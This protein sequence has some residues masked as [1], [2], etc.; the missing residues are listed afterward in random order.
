MAQ[1]LESISVPPVISKEECIYCYQSPYNDVT[2]NELTCSPR[3]SLNVCLHCFQSVCGRH[4]ALHY[5]VVLNVTS[6]AHSTYFNLAKVKK[7]EDRAEQDIKNKKIKL[8]VVEKSEDEIYENLW[9]LGEFDETT[10]S[11]QSLC[12]SKDA[13]LSDSVISKANQILSSKSQDMV[14]QTSSWELTIK[15]CPHVDNFQPPRL[16]LTKQTGSACTDCGLSG[17]LWLCLHCGNVGCG[18]NQVGVEGHSHA[19]KHYESNPT[20]PIA[21]KLGSLSKN[22]SDL[23]CYSC[24][25]ETKFEDQRPFMIALKSYGINLEDKMASEKTLVELQV[26]QNMNWDFQMTDSAGKDLLKLKPNQE[27]G[28]GLINLGNSCYLNSVLQCLFNGGVKAWSLRGLGQDFPQDV[29]YPTNNLTCQ[30]IKLNNA[31]KVEPERYPEGIRPKSFKKCVGQSHQEFSSERQ[32]DAMEFLGYFVDVLDKNMFKNGFNPNDLMKFAM[33]DRLQCVNCGK[34]KYSSEAAESIQLPMPENDDPQDLV[35]IITQYFSGEEVEFTC[36]HCKTLVKAIKKPAFNTYPNTLVVTPARIR[37]INWVPVKTSNELSLPGLQNSNETLDISQFGSEG[38]DP[39]KEELMPEDENDTRFVPN[40]TA[41][42]QL[43]E[44]GFQP[45]GISRALFST[46]N[47]DAESAMEWLFQHVEDPDLNE[48][49]EP[50]KSSNSATGDTLKVNP[51]LLDNMTAMG[52]DQKLSLKAL[53]LNKGDVNRSVEWVFN[54]MD[55][56]GE[57]PQGPTV[58]NPKDY[59]H[60]TP[61]PYELT[62]IICHKGNS[63]HSGHYVAFIRQVVDNEKKWVL[64]NDEKIVVAV[65][66]NFEEMKKNGYIYLYSRI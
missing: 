24:D 21:V 58:R 6:S 44:M 63:V 11:L 14:D 43:A 52:L 32:Q 38:F 49:F 25:D 45:N 2:L 47:S 4:L 20:H 36:P 8:R 34:V 57:L 53:V 31:M 50:P 29:V 3:H 23:Y 5:Q 18:R 51:E 48:P 30:L 54:N 12:T 39:T 7:P 61:E 1:I 17:N 13:N 41:A 56:D 55:D 62:G 33:E 22:A 42:S 16:E 9:S 28:C 46:G 10:L 64:Y 35:Q 26:E 65:P 60:R 27:H 37:P 19:L 66:E 59:G 40:P 15:P